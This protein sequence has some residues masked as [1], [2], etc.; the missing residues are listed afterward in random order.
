MSELSNRDILLLL[1][2]YIQVTD[3]TIEDMTDRELL[4]VLEHAENR[5]ADAEDVVWNVDQG[6]YDEETAQSL[7]ELIEELWAL[8]NHIAQLKETVSSDD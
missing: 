4:Q 8:Q 1:T 5:V 3:G 6:S 2:K 7:D